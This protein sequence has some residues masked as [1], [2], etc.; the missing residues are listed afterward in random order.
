MKVH[1][2]GARRRLMKKSALGEDANG[3]YKFKVHTVKVSVMDPAPVGSDIYSTIIS[4][5]IR[6]APK[7][8]LI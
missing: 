6:A 7:S 5:W 3:M 8:K 1:A 4:F 2:E